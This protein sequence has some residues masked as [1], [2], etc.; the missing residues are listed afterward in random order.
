LLLKQP[1][2]FLLK[3]DAQN[4][5]DEEIQEQPK[6]KRSLKS[7]ASERKVKL[8]KKE[9]ADEMERLKVTLRAVSSRF[10]PFQISNTCFRTV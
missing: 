9:L 5:R 4:E 6:K 8:R 2:E 7:Q 10:E 1:D 3:L